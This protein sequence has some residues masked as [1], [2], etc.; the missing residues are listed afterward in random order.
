MSRNFNVS[1]F[2]Q[3]CASAKCR[4]A[5]LRVS[6]EFARQAN[7]NRNLS[8][9]DAKHVVSTEINDFLKKKSCEEFNLMSRNFNVSLILTFPIVTKQRRKILRLY[10][11]KKREENKK[12]Y[13]KQEQQSCEAPNLMSRNFKVFF[14]QICAAAKCRDAMLR[15]SSEF[16]RQANKNRN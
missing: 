16:A 11:V 12:F 10:S 4:D 5:M 14:Q 8:M 1:F 13:Y 2:K 9:R 3:I 7:K 15:V 6:S